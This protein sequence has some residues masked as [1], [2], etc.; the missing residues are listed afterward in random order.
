MTWKIQVDTYEYVAVLNRE[1]GSHTS[2]E[3]VASDGKT[4]KH[5]RCNLTAHIRLQDLN[6]HINDFKITCGWYVIDRII[7]QR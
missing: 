3:Y 4:G 2:A 5:K 1:M 7:A 6:Q